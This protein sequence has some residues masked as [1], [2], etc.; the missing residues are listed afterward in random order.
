MSVYE[1]PEDMVVELLK[2]PTEE[3]WEWT[4]LCTLNTIGKKPKKGPTS[5]WKKKLLESE[6]S[7]IREL[8]FGFRITVPSWVSVHFV[9]H[10]NGA[11]HYVCTQRNDRQDK[12]DRNKAPQGEMVTHIISVNAQELIYIARKR[13]CNQASPETRMVVKMMCE[14]AKRVCPEISNM[15][16]PNCVY[17]GGLCTE[18]FPCNK[19]EK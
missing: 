6:H 13:L 14:E 8:V 5:E 11:N 16:V 15:L 10:N 17:R 7:P 18:F 3:D 2:Y 1:K 12:Y 19:E 4:Y 9:R